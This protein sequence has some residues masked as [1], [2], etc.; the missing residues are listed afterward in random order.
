MS[1]VPGGST[2]SVASRNVQCRRSMPAAYANVAA[3]AATTP[4]AARAQLF[5][6]AGYVWASVAP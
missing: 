1:R 4:A 5:T 2:G 6:A 3:P